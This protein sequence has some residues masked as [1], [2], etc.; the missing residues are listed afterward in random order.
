MINRII[1][2][3]L[4]VMLSIIVFNFFHP[5]RLIGTWVDYYDDNSWV[6][7]NRTQM[8]YPEDTSLLTKDY[9]T[10]GPGD[11]SINFDTISLKYEN[12]WIQMWKYYISPDYL[13]LFSLSNPLEGGRPYWKLKTTTHSTPTPQKHEGQ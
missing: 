9:R 6:T 2:C 10:T 13:F 1:L 8:S 12:T 11:D 3:L 5:P 7:F 4:L